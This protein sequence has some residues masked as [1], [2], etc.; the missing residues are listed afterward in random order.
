MSWRPLKTLGPSQHY[1]IEVFQGA[2]NWFSIKPRDASLSDNECNFFQSKSLILQFI[3]FP[4]SPNM[5]AINNLNHS[6]MLF[7]K[8]E[9][10][11][12]LKLAS[13][14]QVFFLLMGQINLDTKVLNLMNF[15][16]K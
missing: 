6:Y 7:K 11:A 10:I 1:H 14:Y 16:N 12:H 13:S 4:H 15:S 3:S 5:T 8:L 9:D 2:L